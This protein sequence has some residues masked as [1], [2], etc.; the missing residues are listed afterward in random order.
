M[1]RFSWILSQIQSTD[2]VMHIGCC[3]DEW[4]F[5]KTWKE[6]RSLHARLRD[7]VGNQNLIGTDINKGRLGDMRQ[8]G[9]E[10]LFGNVEGMNLFEGTHFDEPVEP[11]IRKVDVV[12]AGE[13]IEHPSN[14]GRFLD[15]VGDCIKTDGRLILTT[16]NAYGFW[17][18]ICNWVN[19][20][21]LKFVNPEHTHWHSRQTLKAVL[22]R[23]GWNV[24]T[25]SIL[26]PEA[27]SRRLKWLKSIPE[28]I[29]RLRPTLAVSARR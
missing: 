19:Y 6:G 8:M 14:V 21:E 7:L 13:I 12:V 17:F 20:N 11:G 26:R 25:F 16:P 9:Y 24:I 22:Q 1:D 10:V 15:S 27:G 28:A 23:H 29:P 4:H 2:T 18:Q 3:G 5:D